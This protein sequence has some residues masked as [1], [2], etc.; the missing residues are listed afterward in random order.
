MGG[1][2]I[3][4]AVACLGVLLSI[5]GLSA[6]NFWRE[7]PHKQRRKEVHMSNAGDTKR[8]KPHPTLR[9]IFVKSVTSTAKDIGTGIASGLA[10]SG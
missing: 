7:L 5:L 4:P 8:R 1:G 10:L 6:L 2:S 3:P 9:V